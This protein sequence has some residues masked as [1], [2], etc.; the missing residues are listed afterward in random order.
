MRAALQI[1]PV[2]QA[3]ISPAMRA[4]IEAEAADGPGYPANGPTRAQLLAAVAGTDLPAES[5]A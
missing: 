5:V 1:E 4:R 3:A 2:D